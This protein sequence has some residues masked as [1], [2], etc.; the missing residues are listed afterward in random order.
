MSGGKSIFLAS[1]SSILSGGRQFSMPS[2]IDIRHVE[3]LPIPPHAFRW[4]ILL[5]NDAVKIV[6]PSAIFRTKLSG[7]T[8]ISVMTVCS[9]FFDVKYLNPTATA[10][11]QKEPSF[12]LLPKSHVTLFN[13]S[14]YYYSSKPDV[15]MSA[16]YTS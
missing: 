5:R 14:S 10:P 12:F 8:L 6:S 3:H 1:S 4:G 9:I 7:V 2:V 11:M 13:F 15:I 16:G